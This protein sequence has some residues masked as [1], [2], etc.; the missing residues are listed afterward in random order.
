MARFR[1]GKIGVLPPRS[2]LWIKT[3]HCSAS[4]GGTAGGG[5]I[6]RF[7]TR[8]VAIINIMSTPNL[9]PCGRIDPVFSRRELLLKSGAGFG[10]LALSY[11]LRDHPL[12]AHIG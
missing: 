8:S 12:L 7:R 11:L 6:S 3:S 9:P 5:K 1:I 2:V 10:A 4:R